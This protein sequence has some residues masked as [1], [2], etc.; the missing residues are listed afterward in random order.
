M[1]NEQNENTPI[2]SSVEANDFAV[3]RRRV[4][5]ERAK[6]DKA[7]RE[8]DEV[9]ALD[10][11]ELL[12]KL[13]D[14]TGGRRG[15]D[16]EIVDAGKFGFVAV[17]RKEAVLWKSYRAKILKDKYVQTP[18]DVLAFV[19]P[20]VIHPSLQKFDEV[21]GETPAIADVCANALVELFGVKERDD[22]GK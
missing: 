5:E 9:R 10:F 12:L 2:D 6:R 13:E 7:Y 17:A 4:L 21:V 3:R 16:F 15:R 18:E 11:Q 8:Q 14:Q 20:Q 1:A 19:R 22:A